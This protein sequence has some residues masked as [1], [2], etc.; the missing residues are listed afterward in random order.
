MGC[1]QPSGEH[2]FHIM[3]YMN[4]SY[5]HVALSRKNKRI[6]GDIAWKEM[7][8]WS[9]GSSRDRDGI[10]EAFLFWL[11]GTRFLTY[12][13]ANIENRRHFPF[14]THGISIIW[15]MAQIRYLYIPAPYVTLY[16]HPIPF[17]IWSAMLGSRPRMVTYFLIIWWF[18][19][20]LLVTKKKPIL[21]WYF[22]STS[23]L[24]EPHAVISHKKESQAHVFA[25]WNPIF[26]WFLCSIQPAWILP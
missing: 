11:N 12:R 10:F 16:P 6:D 20:S 5:M 8:I 21:C 7:G 24:L 23:L 2:E 14:Q 13:P 17:Q 3:S 26:C 1:V 15:T 22:A 25:A 18:Q 19:R 4:E 9:L